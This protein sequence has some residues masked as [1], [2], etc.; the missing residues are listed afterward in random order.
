VLNNRNAISIVV[1]LHDKGEFVVECLQSVANQ[2]WKNLEMIVVE[3]GSSDSG[4]ALAK[5]LAL[6]DARIRFFDASETVSGPGAARNYGM[7]KAVGEWVLFLDADDFLEHDHLEYLLSAAEKSGPV[8]IVAGGWKEFETNPEEL[9]TR[10]PTVYGQTSKKLI[11]NSLAF[12]PWAVHSAIVRRDWL[13]KNSLRWF[14][15]LDGYP[16][17]DSAFWFAVLQGAKV[18]WANSCGAVYRLD[19]VNSRNA[20]DH[21]AKWLAGLRGVIAKNLETLAAAG[22]KPSHGQI[23]TLV[24]VYES[25]YRE[26]V[27]ARDLQTAEGFRQ[28]ALLWLKKAPWWQPGMLIRKIKSL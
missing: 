19:T 22:K 3:N 8:D 24:R 18:A 20:A 15:D 23:A 13:E 9:V 6:S 25:R 4:P 5:N 27:R 11:E 14:E 28:E 2:S 7:A 12:A 10:W 17:E 16:S 1:T 26:A 21:R